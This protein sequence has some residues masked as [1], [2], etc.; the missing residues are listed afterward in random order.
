MISLI[1]ALR[2]NSLKLLIKHHLYAEIMPVEPVAVEPVKPVVEKTDFYS[3]DFLS[4]SS[5][6]GSWTGKVS[7]L[8][9]CCFVPYV[10]QVKSAQ[11]QN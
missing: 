6:S 8:C 3:K 9:L 11:N 10:F 5:V 4:D 1:L 7:S 2:L